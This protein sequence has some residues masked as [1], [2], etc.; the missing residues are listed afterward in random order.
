VG[1][2]PAPHLVFSFEASAVKS[3]LTRLRS[4]GCPGAQLPGTSAGKGNCLPPAVR[5]TRSEDPKNISPNE[6]L[7]TSH[8]TSRTREL[9]LPGEWACWL[10]TGL[11]LLTG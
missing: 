5:R 3:R 1:D 7:V 8:L 9:S 11:I 6:G 4:A 2:V 10:S